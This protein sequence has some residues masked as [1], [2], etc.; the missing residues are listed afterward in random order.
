MKYTIVGDLHTTHDSL[1][2]VE[3]L[4]AKIEAL[5]NPVILLG[6]VFDTKEII[7]GKCLNKIKELLDKSKLNWAILVGN[8]DK[9]AVESAPEENA[10][11]CL[12]TAYSVNIVDELEKIPLSEINPED[13]SY[14]ALVP[15]IH[16]KEA[17]LEVI[18]SIKNKK[19]TTLF[20]HNDVVG[21]D[22]GNG[23]I[24]ES[25]VTQEDLKGF[26][27][28]IAGHFHKHQIKGNL[29]F[30]GTPFSKNFGESDQVKY[31]AEYDTL[32]DKL[33]LIEMDFP[34]HQTHSL[35]LNITKMDIPYLCDVK[36]YHRFILKGT[37][38]Q[39]KLFNRK[40]FLLEV[41][42][43]EAKFKEEVILEA[44]NSIKIDEHISKEQMFI[45]WGR[46][47]KKLPESCIDLGLQILKGVKN[48]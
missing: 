23:Y 47:I 36:N 1:D 14:I 30:L 3:I 40:A 16:S 11:L 20:I 25:G 45:Q 9:F 29:M 42:L 17:F 31:I 7:R 6:D 38:E 39:I 19:K 41:G 33:D 24:A 27:R 12:E 4:F 37:K 46:D 35:D 28:I 15:Y 44:S 26:K 8:H 34:K 22:Y 18:N 2:K 43:T 48:A 5:G 21:F 13:D 10:L 32:T